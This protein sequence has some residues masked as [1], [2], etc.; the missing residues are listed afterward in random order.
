MARNSDAPLFLFLGFIWGVA[1]ITIM[2]VI[3]AFPRARDGQFE[4]DCKS[5]AHG[6]VDNSARKICAKNG[7]IL[8]HE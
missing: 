8:F 3:F 7:K 2:M 4:K 1:I 5:M 6:T